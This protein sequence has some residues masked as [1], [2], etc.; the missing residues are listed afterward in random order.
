MNKTCPQC[1]TAFDITSEDL[2]FYNKISPIFGNKKY[3]IPA[4][5]L[6]PDCRQQRRAA[7]AN[8]MNLYTRKCDLTGAMVISNFGP[9]S[10]Y[11]VYRQEDWY[12]DKWDSL[13]YGKDFDFSRPFFEQLQELSLAVP[14]PALQRGYTY[15]ENAE[16]TN[17]AGKNKNCYL[18]FDSDLN[19]D[20][21]YSYSINSCESC[22]D[23]YRVRKSEL[24]YSCIDCTGCYNGKFL[25]DCNNCSDSMFLKNCTGSKNCLMSS[26]LQNKEYYVENKQVTPEEFEEYKKKLMSYSGLEEAKK[27]FEELKIHYPQKYT[28]GIQNENISGDY[29]TNCKNSEHC[30]DSTD[31]WDCK[32]VFQAFDKLKDAIDIQECGDG[33]MV[34]ECAFAGYNMY[35]ML[36]SAH[37]LGEPSNQ[38]YSMH[39]PHSKN[40]FGCIGVMRKEYCILNKQY[41][42]E[43]YEIL[44]PKIIEHMK[45]TNEWGEFF[46]ISLSLFPY[47]ETLA[48]DYF[49][50]TKEEVLNKGWKWHD[51]EEVDQKYMGPE[52]KL[53]E[54]IEETDKSIC[55]QILHCEITGKR[56][57]IIPQELDLYQK[58][59]IP[60]PHKC[61][62]QRHKERL[63][64]RNQRK[65]WM[66]KCNKCEME[67]NT[68]YSP[69]KPE[70]VYCEGCY[71]ATIY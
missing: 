22:T 28:H 27:R 32:N 43:E 36:F 61:A 38:I 21:Y 25:Q 11:K 65:L 35:N 55:Q 40:L 53:P 29:L 17:Y 24:C 46:P 5:T 2:A 15:D 30:F 57:K 31:L 67:I 33:E 66:R 58:M 39:S 50:L 23:C 44:V 19:R 54:K 71:L 70:K 41:S 45:S 9:D 6:C 68:S 18:I 47:N 4:P 59:N 64:M 16:Y 8:Q 49:P 42:K 20:C 13:Q 60:V 14:R 10:P 63:L 34:Y 51:E 26:N 62:N 69:D 7:Q 37:C 48:Q 1:A 52:I 3:A 56:F 12:S